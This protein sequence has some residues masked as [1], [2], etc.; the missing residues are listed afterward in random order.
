LDVTQRLQL[1]QLLVVERD[2]GGRLLVALTE[3]LLGF[4][5][6]EEL[7]RVAL[8]QL[9][10]LLVDRLERERIA[11]EVVEEE[12]RHLREVRMVRAPAPARGHGVPPELRIGAG[13]ERTDL[14]RSAP[15]AVH[16][17]EVSHHL[18]A[19]LVD[20]EFVEDRGPDLLRSP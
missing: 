6:L 14:E 5:E 9:R 3:R 13:F 17:L 18:A 2:V 12:T 1:L 16:D 20:A 10:V 19:L 7:A 8:D 11:P 4:P 15:L